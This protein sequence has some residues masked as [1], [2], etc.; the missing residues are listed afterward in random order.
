MQHI[1]AQLRTR[2]VDVGVEGRV[3]EQVVVPKAWD[4]HRGSVQE[5]ILSLQDAKYYTNRC[6]NK[7][8][9]DHQSLCVMIYDVCTI[10]I[11]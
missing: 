10:Y 4:K 7:L 6:R 2:V 11:I 3:S 1:T 5:R 9:T 8:H